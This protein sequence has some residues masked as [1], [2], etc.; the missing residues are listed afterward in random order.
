MVIYRL[1]S[2]SAGKIEKCKG[3]FRTLYSFIYHLGTY[4]KPHVSV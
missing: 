2:L 4:L 3:F 1:N